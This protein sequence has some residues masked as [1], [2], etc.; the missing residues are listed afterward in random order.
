MGR[1]YPSLVHA[2]F[3]M[4]VVL[5]FIAAVGRPNVFT[6]T[7]DYMIHGARFYQA[8]RRT[9]L[10][11]QHPKPPTTPAEAV[12][13]KKLKWQ[14]HFDHSNTG[15]RSPYYGIMLYTLAHRG[16]LWALTAVQAL[17]CAWLLFLLWRSMAP[18][19]PTWTYYT[20]MA[21][22]SLGTSL[23]WVA[24]FAVPD[25]FAA[26]LAMAATLLW[27]Y[28]GHLARWERLGA[29]GLLA[30]AIV[31]HG[32]HLLLMV[33]LLV[34]GVIAARLMKAPARSVRIFAGLSAAAMVVAVA[35][36]SIYG[37]AI[38]AHTGDE[39]RRPPFLVA[40]VL[41]DGPGRAYL[42][43]SCAKGAKWATCKFVHTPLNDSDKILW[44]ALPEDG[45][46]NR[47]NYE[48]RVQME[49]EEMSF[50]LAVV[51]HDPVGQFS[52]SMRNWGLQLVNFWVD[53]PLRR[54]M[55]F[56][57]H[58]YWG[59]TNLVGL[60]RGVGECGRQGEL[61]QPKVKINQL[62][63]VD[64]KVVIGALGL[65]IWGLLR[66]ETLGALRRRS[67][68]WTSPMSRAT[69]ATLFLAAAVVINA[70]V[71]GIV[72]GPFPRYQARVVWLLPAISMLLALALVPAA[73]WARLKARA[74]LLWADPAA[75]A[76]EWMGGAPA[77]ARLRLLSTRIDP[78]FLRY[79]VVGA[80]GFT[81][82][83]LILQGLVHGAGL[84][85]FA[86][87]LVSFSVAVMVT[88]LLNRSWTFRNS[89]GNGRLKEVAVYVGVQLA[90]GVANLSIYT[91]AIMAFPALKAWLLIPLGLGSAAGLCLTFLGAK[92]LAFR[93]RRSSVGS[94]A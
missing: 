9:F 24:G 55:A 60:L 76:W 32:S 7:R 52:A 12:V 21:A 64:E 19:A 23:P 89:G 72:S 71:C 57:K 81:V 65:L 43:E 66:P 11:E 25:I 31:F 67:F 90:G 4:L 26:V 70:A 45:V 83:A 35:A 40:R 2:V 14:M 51:A 61:C 10:H 93:T 22:L 94:A 50:V 44:S 47:S 38:K 79:G 13:Y 33:G 69:A 77:M 39:L 75:G 48:R 87:R 73:Q 34:V 6:D 15:A 62:A 85:Y 92:H 59:K 84:H 3:G 17:A 53:D 30:A 49:T 8:L 18:A 91:L 82:D 54:P 86:G 37:A 56:L 78:A 46:F 63:A 20:L 1:R 88:W 27:I 36:G 42:R 68:S 5:A 29:W 80:T 41:A 74:P 58:D 28:R 16:T